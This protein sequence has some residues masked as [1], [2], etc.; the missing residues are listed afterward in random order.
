MK[1]A[2]LGLD[3]NPNDATDYIGFGYWLGVDGVFDDV[4][5]AE[6]GAFIEGPDSISC[7]R[8]SRPHEILKIR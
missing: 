8:Q 3:W 6:I 7:C 4:P 5:R 1:L 2:V